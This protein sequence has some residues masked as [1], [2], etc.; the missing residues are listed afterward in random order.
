MTNPDPNAE[1]GRQC[2]ALT[3][4]A[5]LPSA[6]LSFVIDPS[7]KVV[8]DLKQNLPATERLWLL[9]KREV[10][11]KA[12]EQ[13]IFAR[14]DVQAQCSSDLPDK[15]AQL[16]ERHLRETLSLLRRSGALIGGYEKV[17]QLVMQKRAAALVQAKDASADGREKL[18]KLAGH[19][20]IP[21][22]TVLPRSA[23]AQ[24]T[25]QE[26]QA[27]VAVLFG[28]LAASFIEESARLSGYDMAE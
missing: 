19:H 23:L 18:A 16:M 9:P 15:V 3:G 14:L 22:I 2:C 21:I 12:C 17:R 10:V 28:G 26:N 5:A 7:G 27:H 13:N 11:Q 25:G 24:I 4:E 20:H 1:K 8:F 6:L